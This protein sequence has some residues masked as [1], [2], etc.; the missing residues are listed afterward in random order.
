MAIQP[1]RGQ[2]Q[3][4]EAQAAPAAAGSRCSGRA[5]VLLADA[6]QV[7]ESAG[8][9]GRGCGRPV[10]AI[11]RWVFSALSSVKVSY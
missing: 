4:K 11:T 7:H 2:A 9:P 8:C 5:Q 10:C 6:A 3:K 1:H